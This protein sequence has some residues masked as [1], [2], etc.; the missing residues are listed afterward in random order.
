MSFSTP[1]SGPQGAGTATSRS[2]DRGR[3]SPV[4]VTLMVLGLLAAS[5][6]LGAEVWTSYLW[7]DQL[8]FDSYWLKKWWVQAALFLAGLVAVAL[9]IYLSLRTAYRQRPIYP[10][11]TREQ[12]ALEQFRRSVDPLRKVLTVAAPIVLGVF[13]GLTAARAWESV[14]LMVHQAPFGQK[15]PIFGHDVAFYVFTLPVIDVVLGFANFVV[16]ASAMAA[17]AG[18]F[19]YGGI[20][21]TQDKG[22][23]ITK[24]ARTHVG[25]IAIA[26]MV[27]LAAQHWC[28]RY[29]MLT[30]SH[31]KF[32]GAH[33]TDVNALIPSKTILAIA[34]LIVAALL[35]VWIVKGNWKLPA[36]GAALIVLS[37]AVVGMAFPALMQ[38]L[39]VNPNERQL[40]A[41]FIKHN[42]AATRAAYNIDD[43]NEVSY[44]A[45]SSAEPGQLREDAATT[46]QIRL[47]D[48]SVVSPTFGQREANRRYWGFEDTLSVDR[49]DINGTKQDTVIGLRE[50]RPDKLELSKQSWVNQHVIYTHGFGVAAAYGNQR[51]SNGEP[52][53]FQ[54]G[55][56]GKGEL[57]EFEERVY[58]GRHSTDYSIVGAPEGA[59]PQEFDYQAGTE[60][61]DQGRQVSNTYQGDGG[62]SVGGFVNRLLY[63]IKFREPNILISSYVNKESQILYDRDPQ[64]RVKAVAPFLSLDTEMYPAVVDG[65]LVW[66]IDGYSTSNRYP[67]SQRTN[68]DS[69][70]TDSKVDG[71]A[72]GH[73]RDEE[74][75]YMRNSVKAT[76]DAFDGRIQ[77]YAWDTEDPIL[78]SWERAFPGSV[79]PTSKISGALMSHLRY[80]ADYFKVQRSVLGKYH[81][82]NPSEF[83]V[84]Q[85]FWQT[86][87]DPTQA[88]STEDSKNVPAQSPYYLTMQ[89]PGMDSPRFSMSSSYTPE[90]GQDVL[91]G[92]LAVDSETGS[93]PGNPAES[94]GK[95]SLLVL[96]SSNPVSAPRQVQNTFN[97]NA[98]VSRELN[99]LRTGNS[100]VISG[101]LLTV[102]VGGGLLYVQPVY[103]KSSSSGGGTSYPLLRKVLV[104]FGDKVGYAD[105]LDGA[106]DAVF[107][108][109]SGARAGDA[110]VPT[111]GKA[112]AVD[113]AVDSGA[114]DSQTS[115]QPAPTQQPSPSSTPAPSATPDPAPSSSVPSSGDPAKDLDQAL[116]DLADASQDADAAMKAGDWQ[117][118]GEAQDRM[119]DAIKRAQDANN[120]LNG[121]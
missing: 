90:Q 17:L 21:W 67:Y 54:S 25:I 50:L 3:R 75:N 2:R 55:V 42:I 51:Q 118:Y 117:A 48:P 78:K 115:E 52:N 6:A 73:L 111:T 81:V 4:A 93:S 80:P 61:S 110:E 108:G 39:Q 44:E 91:T 11:I 102:P 45:Q 22:L 28:E 40:E 57:G 59:E 10:P 34:A 65:R 84:G 79:Q 113:G 29:A 68:F 30:Q 24:A 105:T 49:Y 77:L 69:A 16:V 74:V 112:A 120:K 98:E 87:P 88:A 85:D 119:D 82:T 7:H 70:V 26:Y 95:L 63:A 107:G 56:P 38:S 46:T 47:L 97:T 116:T 96:P 33:Y 27:L 14:L 100:N 15:D 60:G 71:K 53:F 83:Y 19:V 58:F 35:I 99:L 41:E 114:D 106:L 23:E 66:V 103:V 31:E 36:A 62:P 109:D 32:D 5:L 8:G 43:V 64:Q 12:E 72:T 9:P 94:F 13:G 104:S 18:H 101:N 1:P 121:R 20:E 86:S 76:V 89:M 37:T 92:F